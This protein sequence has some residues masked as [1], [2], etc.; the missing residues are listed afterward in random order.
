[1]ACIAGLA[2]ACFV[3]FAWAGLF[4]LAGTYLLF[5]IAFNPSIK[6]HGAAKF[7]DF[8]YGTYL[9]AFPIQQMI[10]R[11]WGRPVNPLILF[12][13]AVPVTLVFAIASWYLVEYPFL[14][15]RPRPL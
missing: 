2:V 7:G 6:L 14:R 4:P 1:M 5:W 11:A 15:L 12:V 10:M 3:P 8:S 13:E 9:Y